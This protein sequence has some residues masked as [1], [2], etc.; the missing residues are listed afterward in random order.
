LI[1]KVEDYINKKLMDAFKFKKSELI[2]KIK[3]GI[4][5]SDEEKEMLISRHES[6]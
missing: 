1:K 2:Q 3:E 4:I 5:F 6:F